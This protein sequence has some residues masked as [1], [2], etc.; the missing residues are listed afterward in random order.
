MNRQIAAAVSLIALMALVAPSVDSAA[1]TFGDYS[2]EK[3]VD[4]EFFTWPEEEPPTAPPPFVLP[5]Q[6]TDEDVPTVT[7]VTVYPERMQKNDTVLFGGYV[8]VEAD[9]RPVAGSVV[10]VYMNE[11]KEAPGAFLGSATTDAE[12]MWYLNATIPFP[13]E[14]KKY[15]I[16]NH[17][18]ETREGCETFLES[19]S[20]PEIGVYS[21]TSTRFE[22]PKVAYEGVAFSCRIRLVDSVGAPVRDRSV[23][24][25][26]DDKAFTNVQTDGQGYAQ[27]SLKFD[28]LGNHTVAAEFGG[29]EYYEGSRRET[30]IEVRPR[31]EL[32]PDVDVGERGALQIVRGEV[33]SLAGIV[34]ADAIEE[35]SRILHA[36]VDG[37]TVSDAACEGECPF[38]DE[39]EIDVSKSG[40]FAYALTAPAD[41]EPHVG[42]ITLSAPFMPQTRVVDVQ[43]VKGTTVTLDAPGTVAPWQDFEASATLVDDR[44]TPL[45]DRTVR[46]TLVPEESGESIILEAATDGSGV[47]T[48]THP[49]L[50]RGRYDASATYLGDDAHGRAAS[51][52]TAVR[53]GLPWWAW[54]IIVIASAALLAWGIRE[55][56][57]RRALAAAAARIP[58]LDLV[59]AQ[60]AD[61]APDVVGLGEAVVL[62]ARPPAAARE[63]RAESEGPV[64]LPRATPVTGGEPVRVIAEATRKG[65]ASIVLTAKSEDGKPVARGTVAFRVVEYAEEVESAY[66]ALV[67]GSVGADAAASRITPREFERFL[68]DADP[69]IPSDSLGRLVTIFEVADYSEHAVRRED[70]L[71]FRSAVRAVEAARR[72]DARAVGT[73]VGSPAA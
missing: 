71:A 10:S 14:A 51:D 72:A 70:Y 8:R 4:L 27:F 45:T 47:A 19:W 65:A 2:L 40:R 36:R 29:D 62:A 59:V 68:L 64:T 34:P 48:F 25:A 13:V 66:R 7:E 67:R 69:S 42:T 23:A 49:D 6:C 57:Q 22:C 20:D 60:P 18:D 35:E 53:A 54:T 43:V 16:V 38:L 37:V 15:H 24:V 5:P 1:E 46:V 73:G 9:G 44:G 12:G 26:L 33:A 11:T 41:A 17:A 58:D 50:E 55:W 32:A 39:F 63:I 61:D 30:Q 21:E 3:R 31:G 28:D 52:A 56:Q